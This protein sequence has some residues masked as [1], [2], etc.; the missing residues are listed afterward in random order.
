M[1]DDSKD[2][3]GKYVPACDFL[4]LKRDSVTALC[5]A[6]DLVGSDYLICAGLENG[7]IHLYKWRNNWTL[8]AAI[9]NR[10]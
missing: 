10:Y 2:L 6:P 5:F 1:Q 3:I 8:I 9:D 4:E 7:V